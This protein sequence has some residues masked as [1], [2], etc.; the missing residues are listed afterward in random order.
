M[1]GHK[2]GGSM[3][4]P[5]QRATAAET[6]YSL[7]SRAMAAAATRYQA[8]R[9]VERDHLAAMAR[10]NLLA[11]WT[12]EVRSVVLDARERIHE[13]QAAREEFRRQIRDFVLALREERQPLP[14][15]L[16]RTRSMLQLLES[17]GALHGDGGWFEAE[18]LEWAIQEFEN[19]S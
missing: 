16:R 19:V 9:E 5:Q 10:H 2:A 6:E 13:A 17:A 15:V 12:P 4:V 11:D 1:T 7:V 3:M 8:L 18:V 14:A